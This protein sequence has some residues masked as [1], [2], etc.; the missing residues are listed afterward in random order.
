MILNPHKSAGPRP[1]SLFPLGPWLRWGILGLFETGH[2]SNQFMWFCLVGAS[3]VGVNY[4]VMRAS[5]ESL[6]MPYVLSSIAAF[7]VATVSNFILN[8]IFTFR[9]SQKGLAVVSK[10][11]GRYLSVTLI[12]LLINLGVLVAL[13]EGINLNPVPANLAGVLVA[14]VGN[15]LGNKLY[16]FRRPPV[17]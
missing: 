15:F 11:F 10:Q 5:Y 4:V 14:T 16:A 8:K 1:R 7:F 6:A 9:D 17:A 3:G 13:V 2:V 12:G